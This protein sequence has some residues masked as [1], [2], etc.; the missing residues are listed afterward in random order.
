MQLPS[1]DWEEG[2]GLLESV[3]DYKWLVAA[4]VLL[5]MVLAYTWSVR[6]PVLYRGEVRLFLSGPPA[7]ADGQAGDTN[8]DRNVRN[9]AEF[10]T[11]PEVLRAAIRISGAD[12]TADQLEK[13]LTVE[14]AKDADLITIRV[15]DGSPKGAAELT[16][17]VAA[18]YMKV[19]RQ[20]A[21]DEADGTI[22]DLDRTLNKLKSDLAAI[23]DRR[24]L[25]PTDAVLKADREATMEQITSLAARKRAVSTRAELAAGGGSFQEESPIPK[26][27][28]Q[29]R[30]AFTALIGGMT[31]LVAGAS[32]AWWLASRSIRF[33]SMQ[34]RKRAPNGRELAVA[35]G[36]GGRDPEVVRGAKMSGSGASPSDAAEDN[37]YETIVEFRQLTTS[38]QQVFRL[39]EGPG[40]QLYEGNVPQLVAEDIAS[41]YPVEWVAVLLENGDGSL[42][43]TGG[44]GLNAGEGQ[45]AVHFDGDMQE[46]LRAG[47]R[48]AAA[49]EQGRLAK[50]GVSS[51]SAD[52]PLMVPLTYNGVGFGMLLVGQG[53]GNGD[54][55]LPA[56]RLDLH[57][58]AMQAR[59]TAPYLRA[60]LLLRSLRTRLRTF[61]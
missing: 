29:P 31:G 37:E 1:S 13:R 53:G 47:P 15:V 5:G 42:K 38:I 36:S 7:Q 27:P 14:P 49:E 8:P 18:A 43:V 52:A 46:V 26:Q 10:L 25:E 56:T 33:R 21:K 22:A 23:D 19:I 45:S 6:Q 30:P 28:F 12:L 48:L 51:N 50:L 41:Q 3:R 60:W 4:I 2:P 16:D 9:Q 55:S 34:W 59:T 58:I 40:Q 61:Q 11:S 20:Q 39:L 57:E 17:A 32:L 54:S 35:G 44:V 24:R